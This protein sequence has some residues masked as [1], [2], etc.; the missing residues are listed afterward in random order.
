MTFEV[1]IEIAFSERTPQF[2]KNAY[3]LGSLYLLTSH[4]LVFITVCLD[5][6]M[7]DLPAVCTMKEF[8]DAIFYV[9]KG[10]R[11]RPLQHIVDAVRAKTYGESVVEASFEKFHVY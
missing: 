8:I 4:L 6:S 2:L 1:Y 7:I 3:L 5:P 11:S 9:G 10:K